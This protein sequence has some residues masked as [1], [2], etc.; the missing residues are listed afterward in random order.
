MLSNDS[1]LTSPDPELTERLVRRVLD[2]T[3]AAQKRLQ[4]RML[5]VNSVLHKQQYKKRKEMGPLRPKKINRFN[6]RQTS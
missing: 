5:Y 2:L 6:L 1:M 3:T 4:E